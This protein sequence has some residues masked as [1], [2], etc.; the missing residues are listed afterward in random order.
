MDE[1]LCFN[2]DLGIPSHKISKMSYII[3][4]KMPSKVI[5]WSRKDHVPSVFKEIDLRNEM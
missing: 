1:R 3:Y 5:M 2:V 4:D